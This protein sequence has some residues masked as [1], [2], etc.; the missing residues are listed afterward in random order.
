[1]GTALGDILP[2]AVA[3]AIRPGTVIAIALL[4]ASSRGRSLGIAFTAG[5]MASIASLS[6]ILLMI[7]DSAGAHDAGAPARWASVTKIVLGVV[8]LA[9]AAR[10]WTARPPH[11]E[12]V[13]Q[14]W[15][16]AIDGIGPRG[17]AGLGAGVG[18]L[19]GKNLILTTAAALSIAQTGIGA[20][21]QFAAMAVYV[22]I[23]GLCVLAPVAV[24]LVLG[25]RAGPALESLRVWLIRHG[26][27]IMGIL[28]LLIGISLVGD[29]IR[30]LAES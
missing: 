24:Y 30:G 9:L 10:T 2:L 13:P 8:L 14:R 7:A 27:A 19:N 17:A 28:L 26:A 22:A 18:A 29:G 1:V 16:D 3:A 5:F 6:A 23:A 12:G 15:L 4:L 11:G 20:I 21:G 25:D